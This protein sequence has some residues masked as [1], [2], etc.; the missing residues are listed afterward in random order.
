MSYTAV[1][2]SSSG[3]GRQYTI[4]SDLSW[5]D[6]FTPLRESFFKADLLGVFNLIM[7]VTCCCYGL[8]VI[9]F[10]N[11]VKAGVLRGFFVLIE[12]KFR[13]SR[14]IFRSYAQ[15]KS[16]SGKVLAIVLSNQ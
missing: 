1:A 2:F 9:L 16:F 5:P 3:R 7:G 8:Y 11:I 12:M 4:R 13:Y 10:V 15:T 6:I 14:M